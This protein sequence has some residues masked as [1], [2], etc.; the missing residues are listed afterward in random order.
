MSQGGKVV[1]S[2]YRIEIS[3][4]Y[5]TQ[6]AEERRD[7]AFKRNPGLQ[8]MTRPWGD[9]LTQGWG[10]IVYQWLKSQGDN[11]DGTTK[12][13]VFALGDAP[14]NGKIFEV[15]NREHYDA[16]RVHNDALYV[17]VTVWPDLEDQARQAAD[18]SQREQAAALTLKQQQLAD[19]KNKADLAKIDR[20]IALANAASGGGVMAIEVTVWNGGNDVWVAKSPS[21]SAASDGP[22]PGVSIIDPG[23]WERLFGVSSPSAQGVPK[24]ALAWQ[25]GSTIT[26]AAQE[27]SSLQNVARGN[28][29]PGRVQMAQQAL[30][31][32][33]ITW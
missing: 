9:V 6:S 15:P 18:Q 3:P 32:A 11:V 21:E 23:S 5:D 33:G 13:N 19:A 28:G 7:A 16:G 10:Q 4:E 8:R 20:E 17:Q 26:A 12:Y 25:G 31:Y 27:I 14:D 2:G 22:H 30:T 29:T 24:A 1:G